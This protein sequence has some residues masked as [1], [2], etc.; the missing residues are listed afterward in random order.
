M[1]ASTHPRFHQKRSKLSPRIARL[2][3]PRNHLPRARSRSHYRRKLKVSKLQKA[4]LDADS[5]G[6][7]GV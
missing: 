4:R 3:H 1:A 6:D 7:S 5:A 2:E